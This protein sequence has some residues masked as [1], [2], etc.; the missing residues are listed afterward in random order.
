MAWHCPPHLGNV[1][2]VVVADVQRLECLSM[3]EHFFRQV[4]QV[5][6]GAVPVVNNNRL[7][8]AQFAQKFAH[9]F[10]VRIIQL[11][12]SCNLYLACYHYFKTALAFS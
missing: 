6:L 4:I 7:L 12:A 11:I 3:T 8:Q 2:D 5:E 1:S 9:V 10:A